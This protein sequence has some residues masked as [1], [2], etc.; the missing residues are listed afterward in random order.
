MVVIKKSFVKI[1]ILYKK[2]N[3][4]SNL[5]EEIAFQFSNI[6][7]HLIFHFVQL[8]RDEK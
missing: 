1:L 8:D 3:F 5:N 7:F 4:S 6:D 2:L